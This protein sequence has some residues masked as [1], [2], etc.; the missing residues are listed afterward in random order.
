MEVT[1]PL[2]VTEVLEERE[3]STTDEVIGLAIRK[4]EGCKEKLHPVARYT[5]TFRNKGQ[6]LQNIVEQV[7]YFYKEWRVFLATNA[8]ISN[9]EMYREALIKV[10]PINIPIHAVIP[11]DEEGDRRISREFRYVLRLGCEGEESHEDFFISI[12]RARGG[13]KKPKIPGIVQIFHKLKW[14]I[15]EEEGESAFPVPHGPVFQD[16]TLIKRGNEIYLRGRSSK[17]LNIIENHSPFR[18]IDQRGSS[19]PVAS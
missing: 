5:I 14:H 13:C 18:L 9:R 1:A 4:E 19:N 7:S 12:T 6:S 17:R 8:L 10:P 3:S 16:L 2:Y 11:L 15:N